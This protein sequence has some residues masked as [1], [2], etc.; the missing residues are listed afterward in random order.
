LPFSSL[1]FP[2]PCHFPTRKENT[3]SSL[4]ELEFLSPYVVF[5]VSIC[6][7]STALASHV[8][9]TATALSAA[10]FRCDMDI[11]PFIS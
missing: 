4:G 8:N 5:E 11:P 9:I 7:A 6:I 3:L 1:V 2:V 10:Y